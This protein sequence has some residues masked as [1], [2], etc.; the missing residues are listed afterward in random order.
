MIDLGIF[1]LP[2]HFRLELLV[3]S[4]IFFYYYFC[5]FF[6]SS[7]TQTVLFT[8]TG[9]TGGAA[10]VVTFNTINFFLTCQLR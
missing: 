9:H 4:I 1:Y 10:S 3:S 8:V 6:P 5:L 7:H 2:A